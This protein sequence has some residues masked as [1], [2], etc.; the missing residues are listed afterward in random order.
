MPI[1]APVYLWTGNGWGKTTS[2]FGVALRSL[3]HGKKVVVVQ[4]M[5]GRKN[6][7]GEYKIQSKLK[8]LTV[9]QFGK[10]SWVNLK[11]PSKKDINL[12]HK[13]LDFAKESLKKKP[14][15]LILDEIN[16]AAK[17]G[18]LEK[19]R[20][21]DL[22]DAAPANMHIYLTGR[23]APKWLIK[24]ANYVNVINTKKGPKK[25]MGEKGIDY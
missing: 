17:I 6:K 19:K 14:F 7:I 12:A 3:G 11:H 24:R 22:L 16:L 25:L 2:A 1:K 9:Q 21:L 4:F 8:N 10:E 15:L 20:I 5:K 23:Y 18:L 13:G